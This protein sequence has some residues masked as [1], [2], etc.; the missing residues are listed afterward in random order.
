MTKKESYE[1]S[2]Y[3][4]DISSQSNSDQTL[5][6]DLSIQGNGFAEAVLAS[7]IDKCFEYVPEKRVEIVGVVSSLRAA[8][9]LDTRLDGIKTS[10]VTNLILHDYNNYY[11]Y[12]QANIAENESEGNDYYYSYSEE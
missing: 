9:Q 2:Y 5:P 10:N 3:S 12:D 8:V 1:V 11:K 6:V 7:I 4:V